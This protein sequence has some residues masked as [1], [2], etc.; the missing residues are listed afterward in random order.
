MDAAGETA[1][2]RAELAAKNARIAELEEQVGRIAGLE[3]QV[4]RTTELEE[5]VTKLSEALRQLHEKLD[6]NSTNSNL[7][8]SSD[9]PGRAA[10]GKR[11]RGKRKRGG[12]K[13]HRGSHRQLLPPEEVDELVDFFPPECRNCWEALPVCRRRP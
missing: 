5:Q 8:P 6:Q 4:G 7:P 13:G 3:E 9:P 10:G 2:L 1:D 12:Q 11:R